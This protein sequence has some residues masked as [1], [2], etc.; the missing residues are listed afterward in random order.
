MRIRTLRW[1]TTR[2]WPGGHWGEA[3]AAVRKSQ[4]LSQHDVADS[5]GVPLSTVRRWEDGAAL[6]DRSLWPKVEEA[7]GLPVPDP[8]VPEIAPA[9][10]E[11]IDTMLLLIDEVKLFRQQ[12]AQGLAVMAPRSDAAGDKPDYL[13]VEAAALHLG[14]SKGAIYRWTQE[15]R[16][17]SHKIGRHVRFRQEDLDRFVEERRRGD[18][19]RVPWQVRQRAGRSP[20]AAGRTQR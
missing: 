4:H 12:L 18:V 10:R 20:R 9:E 17:V 15:R 11:L 19:D 5:L 1:A 6:P 3:F 14:V 8:R 2:T 7:M 16:L 13:D